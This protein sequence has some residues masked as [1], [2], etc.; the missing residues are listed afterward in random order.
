[1]AQGPSGSLLS[2]LTIS[3]VPGAFLDWLEL[4]FQGYL[5]S[6]LPGKM[7]EGGT[8]KLTVSERASIPRAVPWSCSWEGRQL[9]KCLWV[10]IGMM[11]VRASETRRVYQEVPV[12]NKESQASTHAQ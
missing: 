9:E 11:L 3:P 8:G 12:T 1:M 6:Q 5:Y 2:P 7:R 4:Q 10:Q